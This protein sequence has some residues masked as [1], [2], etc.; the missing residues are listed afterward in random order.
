MDKINKFKSAVQTEDILR[1]SATSL[2]HGFDIQLI[3]EDYT[4]GKALEYLLF[5]RH[6]DRHSPTSDK[7]LNF[8]W[9]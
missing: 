6:Y 4:L 7:S 3:G 5:A 9:I 1:T 2:D 8:L